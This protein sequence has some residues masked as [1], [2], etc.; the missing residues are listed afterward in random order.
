MG[1]SDSRSRGAD[2]RRCNRGGRRLG[3]KIAIADANRDSD[4]QPR[5][6]PDRVAHGRPDHSDADTCADANADS[7]T[8]AAP[9]PVAVPSHPTGR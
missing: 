8:D 4:C 1:R 7:R 9:N 5:T 3:G 2:R 6:H